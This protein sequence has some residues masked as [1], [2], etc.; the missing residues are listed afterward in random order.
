MTR[1][2]QRI[3]GGGKDLMNNESCAAQLSNAHFLCPVHFPK[4]G[5]SYDFLRLDLDDF[6]S[7]RHTL[8]PI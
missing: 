4:Y 3:H 7:I 6:P 8:S 1:E 5:A 2:G